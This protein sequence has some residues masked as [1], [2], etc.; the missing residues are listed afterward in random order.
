MKG[1][2]PLGHR[3]AHLGTFYITGIASFAPS[4]IIGFLNH[5]RKNQNNAPYLW[6]SLNIVNIFN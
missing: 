4:S 3:I 6:P 2:P 5:R 1:G